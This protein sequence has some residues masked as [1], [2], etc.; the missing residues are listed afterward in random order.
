MLRQVVLLSLNLLIVLFFSVNIS[1]ASPAAEFEARISADDLRELLEPVLALEQVAEGRVLPQ[2][3]SRRRVV[4]PDPGLAL[5]FHP[6][7]CLAGV[8]ELK[9]A[10]ALLDAGCL[11][12]A[13]LPDIQ[14]VRDRFAV[15]MDRVE[16]G[17]RYTV[18]V[19]SPYFEPEAAIAMIPAAREQLELQAGELR[20][21]LEQLHAQPTSFDRVRLSLAFHP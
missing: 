10:A 17:Q 9:G 4:V 14:S 18:L 1:V 20:Q 16:S 2:L 12:G 15:R 3:L 19:V 7:G 21:Q 8:V 13:D 11:Q 5:V 6:A